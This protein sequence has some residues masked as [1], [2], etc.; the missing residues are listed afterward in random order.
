[1]NTAWGAMVAHQL[2]DQNALLEDP[3][4]SEYLQSV[5]LRLASQSADGG[6]DFQFF[7]IKDPSINAFAVPAA[8]CSCTMGWC[9]P[10]RPNRSWRASWRTKS[11]TSRSTTSRA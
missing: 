5:G 8:S 6:R 11:R 2:R 7:V 4:I 3:E 10:P 9:S 1:M